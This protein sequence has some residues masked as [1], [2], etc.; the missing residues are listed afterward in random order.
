MPVD[1]RI[2]NTKISN[3]ARVKFV[4][5]NLEGKL[6]FDFHVNTLLRKA[7][8]RYHVLARVCNYMSKKKRLILVNTFITSQFF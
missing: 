4:R 5:V 2:A 7:G 8:K 1:I 3:A 6:N